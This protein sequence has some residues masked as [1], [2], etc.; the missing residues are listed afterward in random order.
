MAESSH[1][2]TLN[3]LQQDLQGH[4]AGTEEKIS[5]LQEQ[6]E[7]LVVGLKKR[8]DIKYKGHSYGPGSEDEFKENV[9]PDSKRKGFFK[10][11]YHAAYARQRGFYNTF[12]EEEDTQGPRM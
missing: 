12:K 4:M 7:M 1:Q 10:D 3:M 11:P 2:G 8:N 5:K 6:I 9:S